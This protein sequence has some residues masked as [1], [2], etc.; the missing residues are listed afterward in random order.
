MTLLSKLGVRL[1]RGKGDTSVAHQALVTSKNVSTSGSASADNSFGASRASTDVLPY[2]DSCFEG[3]TFQKNEDIEL[4][5]NSSRIERLLYS[6]VSQYA[7]TEL[8]PELST[9]WRPTK[10]HLDLVKVAVKC[11]VNAYEDD[12]ISP[13][14]G[15]ISCHLE[16]PI[17]PTVDGVTK[18]IK[19]I[20]VK[21]SGSESG[22]QLP[23][24]VV[25]V[26]GTMSKRPVDWLVNFN[27]KARDPGKEFVEIP[28]DDWYAQGINA[29][30]T[31]RVHSGFLNSTEAV[32]QQIKD[33]TERL[34]QALNIRHVLL[35][36]HSAGGAVASLFFLHMLV[37]RGW[38]GHANLNLSLVTFGC[39]PVCNPSINPYIQSL[40]KKQSPP[41]I[42]LAIVNESDPVPRAD[43]SF[44]MS[45][46]DM[47]TKTGPAPLKSDQPPTAIWEFPKPTAYIVGDLVLLK[48]SY[49]LNDDQSVHVQGYQI[50]ADQLGELL[51]YDRQMHSKL[52]YAENIDAL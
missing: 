15:D 48:R 32:L 21:P 23:V 50:D 12:G 16:V 20:S 37:S 1:G 24:L 11:S 43:R 22:F 9:E 44:I 30:H 6:K 14:L 40:L 47:Y 28:W 35:T 10:E 13:D 33:H 4:R 36:G 26:R 17:S 39:P 46:L 8:N 42:A 51:F 29:S 2:L 25:A 34:T 38:P 49:D 18:A 27:H 19:I 31:L 41:G 7:N 5:V 3:L 52:V 45:M